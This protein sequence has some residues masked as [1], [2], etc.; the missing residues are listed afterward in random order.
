[1]L[2]V[3][4]N[5]ISNILSL[6]TNILVGILYTPYLVKELGVT[7]YGIIPLS[8]LLNQYINILANSLTR[9][10]TRFYSV[11]YKKGDFAKASTFFSSSIIFTGVLAAVLIPI[12]CIPIYYIDR[13][14]DIPSDLVTQ[15]K[16]LFILS[17]ISFFA[18]I[19]TN[20]VNITI[21]ADNRLDLINY[22]KISRNITKLAFNIVL[23]VIFSPSL[24]WV[25][26]SY[27]LSEIVSV[28]LS[29]FSYKATKPCEIS[30]SLR[31]FE[32]SVVRPI[33]SMITWVALI[34]FADTFIYKIDS[35][36]ITNYFGLDKTGMLGSMSEFGSYCISIAS[37]I[38][39][40]FGPLVLIAYS[41]NRHNEV[42]RLTLH[43]GY[44]VGLLTC[45]MCGVAIGSSKNILTLWLTPDIAEYNTWMI[46]KLVVIPFT[47]VGGIYATV[48]NYWN[49]VKTPAIVSV[50][51]SICYV[52]LS[53]ILL[54]H[55]IGIMPF[56]LINLCAVLSQ[57]FL[58][59]TLILDSIYKDLRKNLCLSAI[60]MI[61]YLTAT[62]VS[63]Y[64]IF[65]LFSVSSV[66]Q[67]VVLLGMS[68]L[69][70]CAEM[71]LFL[72]KND[73]TF[74]EIILPVKKVLS[75]ISK[76]H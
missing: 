71:L 27:L 72:N 34:S 24:I 26:V 29:V 14:F 8:L 15:A 20:C 76:K 3:R 1:M 35:V 52:I 25:G 30:F 57:G 69:L 41:E 66:G 54:N 17:I 50:L 43:G 62:S 19:I 31:H 68:C 64:Y 46:I 58:M 74:L 36:L 5:L 75:R 55:R 49:R 6:A 37:V 11:E 65:S 73:I 60:K 70:G 10:V 61:A 28:L 33:F 67:L 22:V 45:L 4:K 12:C 32:L 51:I 2:Q 16:E 42:K 53:V 18:S 7:A 13:L 48:Y 9:A 44:V 63:T 47:T 39:S 59:N 56:L 40:L 23:F 21:F 38:G